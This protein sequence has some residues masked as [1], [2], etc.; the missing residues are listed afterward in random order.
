MDYYCSILFFFPLISGAVSYIS[1]KKNGTLDRTLVA[2]VQTVE[3]L[4]AYFVSEGVVL[5]IQTAL[6]FIIMTLVFGITVH[7]PIFWAFV[8]AA[9]IGFS[10]LSL[11]KVKI[12][13]YFETLKF[14]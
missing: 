8:L 4:A 13:G 9:L 10:G 6:I 14:Y 11:G 3:I 12:E 5:L 7:G 1:D 2:G